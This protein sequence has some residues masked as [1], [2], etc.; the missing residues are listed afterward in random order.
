MYL[1]DFDAINEAVLNALVHN[2]WTVTEP[3]ISLFTDRMEILIRNSK[4]TAEEMTIEIES[5]A[6]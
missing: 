4:K 6:F 1:F 3:R 2:D 5:T